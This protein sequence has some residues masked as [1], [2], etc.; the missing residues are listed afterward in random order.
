MITE[1]EYEVVGFIKKECVCEKCHKIMTKT[2]AMLMS[3]PP[4]YEFRCDKCG[5][6]DYVNCEDIEGQWRLVRKVE[7]IEK[8]DIEEINKHISCIKSKGKVSDGY[9]TFDELY[10]HRA[11]LFAMI[12]NN[13]LDRAWKSKLHNTGDMYDGMFIVG[14]DSPYG[15]ITYHYDIDPY[16]E[17]FKVKELERAPE[18]D[19][20]TAEDCINR[21][22][23]WATE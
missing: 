10:H 9:H 4:Q 1:T 16:W 5:K 6:V 21:M 20:S 12:C 8:K 3:N 19:G 22:E 14:I 18:W 2:Q 23:R 13:N 17:M 11:V 7:D 15:Q